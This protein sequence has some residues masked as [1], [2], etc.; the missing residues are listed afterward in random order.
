AIGPSH[1][2]LRYEALGSYQCVG[3]GQ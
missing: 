2:S 1:A 3:A